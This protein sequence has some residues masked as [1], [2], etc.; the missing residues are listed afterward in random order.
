MARDFTKNASNYMSLGVNQ[1]QPLING[2][3]A[4][5]IHAL[6]NLDSFNTGANDNRIITIGVA[7]NLAG[8]IM[9]VVGGAG[10]EVLKI[11]GR[12][13]STDSLQSKSATTVVTTSVWHSIGGVLNIGGDTITPY[14][15]GT[16]EGSGAVTFG[17][18]TWTNGT[19]TQLDTIGAGQ[20]APVA[21]VIQTDGRIAELALWKA[22]I[23]ASGFSLLKKGSSP[24]K[25]NP[26][27]LILYWPLLGTSSPEVDMASGKNGTIT[28]TIDATT[29]PFTPGGY[30]RPRGIRPRPFAPGI[31]R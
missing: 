22:D 4:I 21:T 17:N 25:I 23:G 14:Y 20:T 2:A 1:V 11:A 28:G 8:I 13:V 6:V 27:N 18:A 5:S 26:T 19:P 7:N 3:S 15:E 24:L 30:L 16:A 12:S 29:H 9:E 10:A 31:A